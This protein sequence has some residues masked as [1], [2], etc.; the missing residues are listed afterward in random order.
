MMNL[1]TSKNRI[2]FVDSLRGFALLGMALTH[3]R[4]WFV[5]SII[6][7]I[8]NVKYQNDL[9]SVVVNQFNNFFIVGKFYTIFS[10]L[11]GVS[12]AIQLGQ[13]KDSDKKFIPRFIWRLL[14]LFIIGFIH[15]VHWN[16]D[17]LG[18]YAFLGVFLILLR[19]IGSKTLLSFAFFLFLFCLVF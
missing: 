10:L 12:F 1:N 18:V 8:I 13:R 15:H 19:N 6:P 11:F 9:A 3:I 17:V 14:I 4:A 2:L 5:L 7:N 16:G